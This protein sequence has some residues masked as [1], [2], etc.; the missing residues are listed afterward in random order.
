MSELFTTFGVNW[1]LLLIQAVN[2]GV[3]LFALTYFL[4]K[5]L[6]AML[7]E[8]KAT[9]AK[10]IADAK[11]ADA[12]LASA[13]KERTAVLAKA[14]GDAE[15]IVLAAKT[16]ADQ[17]AAGIVNIAEAKAEALIADAQKRG[18]EAARRVMAESEQEI[19]RSAVL[20]AEKILRQKAA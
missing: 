5:P 6:M 13:E 8:R 17:K 20:A 2:F 19:A 11:D 10:G 1:K 15:G 18:D 7:D 3:L 16:T 14:G 4:Y 9:I 12:K